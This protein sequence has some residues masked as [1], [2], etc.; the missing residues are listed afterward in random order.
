MLLQL[1]IC[2]CALVDIIAASIAAVIKR[3]MA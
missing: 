1:T 2:A 3:S